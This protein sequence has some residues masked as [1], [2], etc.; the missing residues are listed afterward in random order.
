MGNKDSS[1]IWCQLTVR[2]PAAADLNWC[3]GSAQKAITG[4]SPTHDTLCK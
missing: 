3:T 1:E 4:K 2:D